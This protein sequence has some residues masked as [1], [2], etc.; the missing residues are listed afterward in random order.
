MWVEDSSRMKIESVEVKGFRCFDASGQ[1]VGLDDMTCL[2]GPNASGKTAVL[3]A[4]VRLLGESGERVV[5]T[6]D[7]H[8]APGERLQSVGRRTLSI[9]ARLVFPELREGATHEPALCVPEAFNQ[10]LVDEE[11]GAPYCRVRLE[12]V[13]EDDGTPLGEVSQGLFWILTAAGA[14]EEATE[15][16]RRKVTPAERSRIKVIYIPASREPSAQIKATASTVFGR[17]LRSLDWGTKAENLK[18]LVGRVKAGLADLP[19][20]KSINNG[21]QSAWAQ[22][23]DGRIA[24]NVAFE[25]LDD[26]PSALLDSLSPVFRPSEQGREMASRDLSDGLRSLFALSLPLGL[27]E[28]ERLLKESAQEAGFSPGVVEGLPL[29]TVF[30]VEEPENHLSPHYLGKIVGRLSQLSSRPDAQVMLS[31]HSPSILKRIEPDDVRYLLGGELC[32]VSE[33][34][35]LDLPADSSDEA[36]K[37][38]REAVKGHPELYFS[39]VVVL[40][41]GPSEEIILEKLFA[42]GGTGLD[43]GFISVVPLAGRHVNYLWRLLHALGIPFVTLLDLDRE[44]DGGGWGRVQYVRDQLV[45]MHQSSPQRLQFTDS[46]GAIQSLS[47]SGFADLG[48]QDDVEQAAQLDEWLA[49]LRQFDV[50]FSAPLD[51]DFSLLEAFPAVYE[52]QAPVG[53]GPRFPSGEQDRDRVMKSRARQ[54][55]GGDDAEGAAGSGASYSAAQL[56]LFPW[57]KYLFLDRSKPVAHMRALLSLESTPGWTEALPS[58]LKDLL[59]RVR[60][61][62]EVHS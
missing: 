46:G 12:A 42:Q 44:R 27:F 7:F 3:L 36:F 56:A 30:A 6:S 19:G 23:Y 29:L 50:F 11:G 37:Y 62:R 9:E 20:I 2:V 16:N 21:V 25:S 14:D 31:S 51:L 8:L 52:A 32:P 18:E 38:I 35:A 61:L 60:E 48:S 57:Y 47:N 26:D 1:L 41:E 55:L 24:G 33:V 43:A 40:G 45:K 59:A 15:T 39:R 4:L 5:R 13:W 54:V 53:G 49:Q 34:K 10:M 58:V 17:L 28:V 22:V